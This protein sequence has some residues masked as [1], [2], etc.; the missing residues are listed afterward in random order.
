MNKQL[1]LWYLAPVLLAGLVGL[2]A[3]NT[4][5]TYNSLGKIV[6]ALQ[7][8][9]V[10]ANTEHLIIAHNLAGAQNMYVDGNGNIDYKGT[11]T[12]SGV[13]VLPS[14]TGYVYDTSG[15]LTVVSTVGES[16]IARVDN[17]GNDS[18]TTMHGFLPKLDGNAAHYMNGLGVWGTV[19]AAGSVQT[20]EYFAKGAILTATGAGVESG[21]AV[22]SNGTVLT[23][24]S[25]QALGVKWNAI[26]AGATIDDTAGAGDTTHTWSANQ[27]V[28]HDVYTDGS[29]I[30]TADDDKIMVA[31]VTGIGNDSNTLLLLH[32]NG[33]DAATTFTDSAI[34]GHAPRTV[35]AVGDAQLDTAAYKFGTASFLLDGTGDYA[36]IPDDSDWDFGTSNFTIE[37]WFKTATSGATQTLIKS[38]YAASGNGYDNWELAIVYTGG[39]NVCWGYAGV[40]S[41]H[42]VS[43][44][45]TT[46]IAN[47][48]WHHAAFVRNGD[49]YNLYVDGASEATATTGATYAFACPGGNLSLGA[50]N[51]TTPG[52]HPFTGHIDEIRISKSARYTSGF[53]PPTSAFG[54]GGNWIMS[55]TKLSDKATAGAATSSGLTMATNKLLGRGTASTGA[56]EE[57]T[58]GT[59]F[60][61]AGTTLNFTAAGTGDVVGPASAT[62][63]NMPRFNGTTGKLLMASLMY[64]DDLGSP[65]VP[66][67]QKYKINGTAL[68]AADVGALAAEADTLATTTARGASTAQN[69]TLTGIVG[70]TGASTSKVVTFNDT[71]DID[72]GPITKDVA[73]ITSTITDTTAHNLGGSILKIVDANVI[74]AGGVDSMLALEIVTGTSPTWNNAS[75]GDVGIEND[76]EVQGTIYA[77]GAAPLVLG[78]DAA[79]NTA[80]SLKMFSAGANAY[81]TTITTGEQTQNIALTL[82]V[83]DGDSGQFLQTNG[84]G[85]LSWAAASGSVTGFTAAETTASPNGTVYVDSLTA[86]G[87][88]TNADAALVPKGTGA[89]LAAVP[90]G[91]VAG[92]N[93]RGAYAV[94]WQS[95]RAAAAYVASGAYATISGGSG[96]TASATSSTVSG[97]ASGVASGTASTVSGGDSNTASSNYSTVS[98][99]ESNTASTATHATVIGGYKN[100]A[101]G[102][103]SSSLGGESN[104]ASGAYSCTIGGSFA[105]ATLRGQVSISNGKFGEAGDAQSSVLVARNTTTN[106]TP[107]DL[108]LDGSSIKVTIASDRM[109]TFSILVSAVDI[110]TGSAQVEGDCAGYRIDGVIRNLG[111][112]TAL[113]GAVTVTVI[114]ESVAGWDATVTADDTNDAIK[115]TVTG[116]ANKN[117]QWVA[118]ITLTEIDW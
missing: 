54:T 35:T 53:T 22:G 23:A 4:G 112:T 73:K 18:S 21:L 47:N 93:K 78:L 36:T 1:K 14:G 44:V 57:I 11:L 24:D 51:W 71:S 68:A 67:G 16:D 74:D 52:L 113:V 103:E 98:G 88:S 106:A 79:T 20:S 97:G 66:T 27:L 13:P 5:I 72:G 108:F 85:V 17:P 70:W 96:G 29:E 92:G 61:F 59:G 38:P 40:D 99:G 32:F 115:L 39:K 43:L 25:T 37:C 26:S 9:P 75:A 8:Y 41:G 50:D 46:E 117:I 30:V 10:A 76:L 60:S 91:T 6:Q 69:L 2:A 34:G 3:T 86:A 80:G 45:A 107:T 94:D 95:A 90:D 15:V 104:T 102:A 82:P 118:R 111:G 114:A 58:L 84:S 110:G 62:S 28:K 12:T 7:M 42:T 101:S 56:I 63:G 33:A 105:R 55:A 87:A 19:T 31:D 116:E 77:T 64:V 100:A 48:A 81:Y 109:C 89:V 49:V 65:N 83:N